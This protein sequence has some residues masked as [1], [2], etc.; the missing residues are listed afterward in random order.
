MTMP[1]MTGVDLSQKLLDI[2]PGLPIIICTG[3]SEEIDETKA[4]NLGIS[5]YVNKPVIQ[6]VL[7]RTIQKV[8]FL[9]ELSIPDLISHH[10]F[11]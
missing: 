8:L 5:G 6:S 4:E 1:G 7:A 3:F 11:P 10:M 2:K 9:Q